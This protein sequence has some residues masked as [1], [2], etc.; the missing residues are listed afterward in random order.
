MIGFLSHPLTCADVDEC[1]LSPCNTDTVCINTEGSYFCHHPN[2][3][4]SSD[5]QVT[6]PYS[7]TPLPPERHRTTST[8]STVSVDRGAYAPTATSADP[9][10]TTAS[11][12]R[13]APVATTEKVTQVE[14]CSPGY[15]RTD[16]T[17]ECEGLL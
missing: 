15:T 8:P 1:L 2:S 12:H 13:G 6:T 3:V 16:P 17:A 14:V 10:V 9:V 5:H 11:I 4:D 7:V